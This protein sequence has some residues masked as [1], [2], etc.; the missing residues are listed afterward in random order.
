MY[1]FRCLY[2]LSLVNQ[3]EEIVL[4]AVLLKNIFV[5]LFNGGSAST[6]LQRGRHHC[7]RATYRHRMH[8]W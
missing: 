3:N 2:I 5:I 1:R 7:Q 6:Y 4:I 8:V